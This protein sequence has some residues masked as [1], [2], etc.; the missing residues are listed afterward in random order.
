MLLL[1]C[2]SSNRQATPTRQPGNALTVHASL[3]LRRFA[4]GPTHLWQ[5]RLENA[6]DT[7]LEVILIAQIGMPIVIMP[8]CRPKLAKPT[9][10]SNAW[11][12]VCCDACWMFLCVVRG[13][14]LPLST[15]A[16]YNTGDTTEGKAACIALMTGGT[17]TSGN[18]EQHTSATAKAARVLS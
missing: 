7:A 6:L 11:R 4:V 14:S 13:P 10:L 16:L 8:A 12:L 2:V 3:L 9:S 18:V 1:L 5:P 17:V 15:P